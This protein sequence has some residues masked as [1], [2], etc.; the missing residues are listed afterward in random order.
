M[1]TS[2]PPALAF[3]FCLTHPRHV[4]HASPQILAEAAR[5]SLP[6]CKSV[7]IARDA[8]QGHGEAA[9]EVRV[10]GSLINRLLFLQLFFL[11]TC[12]YL[13]RKT[14]LEIIILWK[15]IITAF[16]LF[17]Y[18]YFLRF[19]KNCHHCWRDCRTDSAD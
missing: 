9:R 5:T 17:R 8:F 2:A 15:N 13:F 18:F 3:Y 11:N 19:P 6:F 14:W 7:N 16:V 12:T 1:E 10:I 4:R